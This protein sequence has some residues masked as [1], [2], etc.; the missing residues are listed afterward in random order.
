MQ[1]MPP[2]RERLLAEHG[3]AKRAQVLDAPLRSMDLRGNAH[4]WYTLP[5]LATEGRL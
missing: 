4:D 1:T 3:L 5:V 2:I